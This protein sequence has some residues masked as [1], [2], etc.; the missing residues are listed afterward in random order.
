VAR[1]HPKANGVQL[2]SPLLKPISFLWKQM[3]YN[4]VVLLLPDSCS[5]ELL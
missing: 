5:N 2:I 4:F 1:A 3:V